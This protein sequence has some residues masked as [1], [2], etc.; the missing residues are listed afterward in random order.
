M[1]QQDKTISKH[2]KDTQAQEMLAK[3][4][5]F[6]FEILIKYRVHQMFQMI[7]HK[8]IEMEIINLLK[9]NYRV[10]IIKYDLTL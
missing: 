8:L 7:I 6:H 4:S 3:Y 5:T 9:S 1:F 2:Y 10:N